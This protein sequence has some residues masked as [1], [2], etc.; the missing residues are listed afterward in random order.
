MSK[1]EN[2]HKTQNWLKTTKDFGRASYSCTQRESTISQN[3]VNPLEFPSGII[4]FRWLKTLKGFCRG[5][6][7][8]Y[9]T[10]SDNFT[11]SGK[12]L[13][14]PLV[15]RKNENNLKLNTKDFH[16]VWSLV[17]LTRTENFAKSSK[18]L[19]VSLVGRKIKF[20]VKQNSKLKGERK[21]FYE[22]ENAQCS[23]DE[24]Q[25]IKRQMKTTLGRRDFF[26]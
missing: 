24:K 11:K 14:F 15:G 23:N 19:W 13:M 9:L 17:C 8:V 22:N 18:V 20:K 1:N 10:W 12:I 3:R 4:K 25:K 21:F 2:V 26:P 5:W 7:L 6:S 16:R